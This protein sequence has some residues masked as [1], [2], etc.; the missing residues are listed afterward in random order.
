MAEII[1][2]SLNRCNCERGTLNPPRLE[3]LQESQLTT[4]EQV[5]HSSQAVRN[6]ASLCPIQRNPV[7]GIISCPLA[8][9]VIFVGAVLTRNICDTKKG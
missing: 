6:R 7:S 5:L 8:S 2:R 9:I 1:K 3:K 4:R